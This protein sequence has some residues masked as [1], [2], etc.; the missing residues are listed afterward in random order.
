MVASK[1]P[2]SD[3]P[4]QAPAEAGASLLHLD[5]FLN[6]QLA[7]GA[8]VESLSAFARTQ[9][10]QRIAKRAETDWRTAYEAFLNRV[11]GKDRKGV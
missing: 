3:A 11:P 5:D 2:N 8:G 6:G 9:K 10:A 4:T 7:S 1:Q